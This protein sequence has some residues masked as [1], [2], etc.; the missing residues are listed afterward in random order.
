MNQ[1]L[2]FESTSSTGSRLAGNQTPLRRPGL[3]WLALLFLALVVGLGGNTDLNAA[4]LGKSDLRKLGFAGRYRGLMTGNIQKWNGVNY[5]LFP[6]NQVRIQSFPP[7]SGI[8]AGPSGSNGFF[9]TYGKPSGNERRVKM[10]G[11]YNGTSFNTEYGLAMV[12]SGFK[13]ITI[14]K[15]GKSN[16]RYAMTILD[17]LNENAQ[18]GG[19][20]YTGWRVK[21][22]MT[23]R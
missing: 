3:R 2:F 16:P 18:V 21:G 9:L 4:R 7:R 20:L 12:G 19:A 17:A 1:T 5:T 6:V 15:K 13:S 8:I 22:N 10:R 11:S 23:K 14:R